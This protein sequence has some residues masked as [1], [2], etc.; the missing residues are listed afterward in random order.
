VDY[1]G[2]C[3]FGLR[4]S[5]PTERDDSE[6]AAFVA[7]KP[8]PDGGIGA[9]LIPTFV[10]N[11]WAVNENYLVIDYSDVWSLHVRAAEWDSRPKVITFGPEQS[12]WLLLDR[13]GQFGLIV[14]DYDNYGYLKLSDWILEQP[15]TRNHVVAKTWSLS[16]PGIGEEVDWPLGEPQKRPAS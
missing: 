4:V 3:V 14:G 1:A 7:L 2:D 13:D 10:N 9:S 6:Q 16:L 12:G 11:G 8:R 15:N 5:L